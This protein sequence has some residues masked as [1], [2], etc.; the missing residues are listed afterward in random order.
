[1]VCC[2]IYWVD[3]IELAPL[4][5]L[6]RVRS[7]SRVLQHVAPTQTSVEPFHPKTINIYVRRM[8]LLTRVHVSQ[9]GNL[10]LPFYP[11]DF[12][13]MH[14]NY[15]IHLLFIVSLN[16][17]SIFFGLSCRLQDNHMN[18]K[19]YCSLFFNFHALPHFFFDFHALP[20]FFC[21][22]PV[23]SMC[24]NLLFDLYVDSGL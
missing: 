15:H 5:F 4:R 21:G 22:A 24:P 7:I 18:A 2:T 6:H 13:G 11:A 16:F 12:V 1:M 14:Q 19:N 8:F 17:N 23:S 3:C 10:L 20:P 9:V